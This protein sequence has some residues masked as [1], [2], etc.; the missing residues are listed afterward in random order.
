[1]HKESNNPGKLGAYTKL[2]L[3]LV[4]TDPSLH[5]DIPRLKHMIA[6]NFPELND[7]TKCPNC[8]ANMTEYKYSLDAHDALLLIKLGNLF[9]GRIRDM[10]FQEANS[11]QV[12]KMHELSH[13]LR[14]RTSQ[15]R[16]LG[17][18]AKQ[19]GKGNHWLITRRG[20][21]ALRGEHVP[22]HVKVWRNKIIDRFDEQTTLATAL[23]TYDHTKSKDAENFT[24]TAESWRPEEWLEMSTRYTD[25]F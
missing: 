14:C 12:S 2:V 11:F 13:L 21:A 6:Y 19:E 16:V 5:D 8:E 9:K 1:M 17:L 3:H 24:S 23:S 22:A 10:S 4:R 7:K 20:F 15:C 25:F 18:L